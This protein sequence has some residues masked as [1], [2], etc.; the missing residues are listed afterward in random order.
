MFSSS[1][2]LNFHL[3]VIIFMKIDRK[4]YD[5]S[6][7][8]AHERCRLCTELREASPSARAPRVR[9][10][11]AGAHDLP[12][13]R[14]GRLRLEVVLPEE[15]HAAEGQRQRMLE[16]MFSASARERQPQ[17]QRPYR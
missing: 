14:R 7:T 8:F 9:V 13:P 15:V 11:R 1:D 17:Q 4:S 5:V 3:E 2:P 6:R 12:R 16:P 10:R